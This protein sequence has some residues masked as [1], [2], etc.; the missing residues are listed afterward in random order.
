MNAVIAITVIKE[1]LSVVKMTLSMREINPLSEYLK[2]LSMR[3]N[4]E[5]YRRLADISVLSVA[6]FKSM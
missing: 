1:N 6:S 5:M 4:T 3:M 2:W